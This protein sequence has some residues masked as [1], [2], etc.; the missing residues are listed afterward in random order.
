MQL[1]KQH[2][3]TPQEIKT[4]EKKLCIYTLIDDKYTKLSSGHFLRTS[5]VTLN[6]YFCPL[7]LKF[8]GCFVKLLAENCASMTPHQSKAAECC[9]IFEN[10][11]SESPKSRK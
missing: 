4:K 10:E 7:C 5:L 3:P 9:Q 6:Y 1:F 8:T 11:V 2:F